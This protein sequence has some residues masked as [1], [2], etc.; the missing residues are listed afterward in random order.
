MTAQVRSMLERMR[1]M[2]HADRASLFILDKKKKEVGAHVT[3][4]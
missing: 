3:A 4:M 1:E 2:V